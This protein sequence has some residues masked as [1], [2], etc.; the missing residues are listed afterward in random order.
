MMRR[1]YHADAARLCLLVI[2]LAAFVVAVYCPDLGRG[3]VKDDF[4]WIRTARSAITQ[5]S[6]LILQQDVGFY[7]PIVTLTFVADY[8]LHGWSS[9]GYGW[10]NLALYILCI[11]SIVGLGL[12]I[13]LSRWAAAVSGF[14]WAVNPHGINMALLWLSG[15]T[16]LLLTLFSVLA[17]MAFVRKRYGIAAVLIALALL[18]KEEAVALP[19]I[20]LIWAWLRNRQEGVPGTAIAAAYIP[21]GVYLWMRSLTP[22]LTVTTAPAFYQF[23]T[24]PW[25][26]FTNLGEYLDRSGTVVAI[27]VTIAI[28]VYRVLPS[29]DDTNQA[30]LQLMV[31]WWVLMFAVTIWLPVRS[32]LYAVCPSAGAAIIGGVVLERLRLKAIAGRLA[33]EPALAVLLLAAIPIYHARDGRRVEAAR[34]SARTIGTIRSDLPTLPSTGSVVFHDEPD[35]APFREAFGDL[36]SE[37]LRTRFSREWDARIEDSP[38]SSVASVKRGPIIAEYWIRSG[39]IT[40]ASDRRSF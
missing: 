35:V 38:M 25:L 26:L 29:R 19:A 15:R 11:A 6:T 13:G 9:R 17:G 40:R 37:A 18:S 30:V 10:T 3:F 12:S 7:R 20:L 22:A 28:I 24:D 4:T 2:A 27:V 39:R 36:A 32:S 1:W 16:A 34:I 5:P 14:L 23:T 21:L 33:L 8:A 31:V